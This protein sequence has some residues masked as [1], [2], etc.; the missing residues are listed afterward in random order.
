M[1]GQK[2][3]FDYYVSREQIDEHR[4]WRMERRLQSWSGIEEDDWLVYLLKNSIRGQDL[5]QGWD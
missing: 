5:G 2:K 1:K 4:S 3:G